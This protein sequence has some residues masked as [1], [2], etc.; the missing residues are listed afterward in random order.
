MWTSTDYLLHA[1]DESDT[2]RIMI[3]DPDG[4]ETIYTCDEWR[5]LDLGTVA[6]MTQK[7]GV[8]VEK[9]LNEYDVLEIRDFLGLAEQGASETELD[10]FWQ[11]ANDTSYEVYRYEC[12]ENRNDLDALAKYRAG[13]LYWFKVW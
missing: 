2:G 6:R 5:A 12:V 8:F 7:K 10:Y 4:T 13:D 3:I 11:N 9:T 1:P